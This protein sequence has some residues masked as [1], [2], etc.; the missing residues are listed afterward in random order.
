MRN[1]AAQIIHERHEAGVPSVLQDSYQTGVSEFWAAIPSTPAGIES[2][3]DA[4]QDTAQL[5]AR[6]IVGRRFR[7]ARNVPM[8][9]TERSLLEKMRELALANAEV[10]LRMDE[11]AFADEE[12]AGNVLPLGSRLVSG[13][14]TPQSLLQGRLHIPSMPGTIRCLTDFLAG[15]NTEEQNG[16]A[17]DERLGHIIRHD[18]ALT[19]SLLRLVNSPL[20]EER[21][22]G[23]NVATV[24]EAVA[25]VGG[26][27]LASLALAAA[28]IGGGKMAMHGLSLREFW[29]HSLMTACLASALARQAGFDDPERFFT[30]GLL[31]DVGRL[32]LVDRL[33]RDV[34]ALYG[35]AAAHNTPFHLAERRVLG[36]EHGRVG[37]ELMER[38][39]LDRALT[40]A[41]REHHTQERNME[42]PEVAAVVA[43]ADCMARALGYGYWHDSH[44]LPPSGGAWMLLGI[45][46]ADLGGIGRQAYEEFE[47]ASFVFDREEE[48][49]E[50]TA[51]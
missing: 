34:V 25:I 19:L 35:D 27:Q 20:Y 30:A 15:G 41:V 2:G 28:E 10:M 36:F 7:H 48:Q 37:A 6:R 13:S 16:N 12:A 49:A 39:N 38:W 24:R 14:H 32:L 8:S 5:K 26:R 50:R 21:R 3:P 33:G 42:H 1:T 43:V 17:S 29:R 47:R 22:G 45:T 46:M 40:E 31:H 18:I 51:A 11:S 44:V 4:V 9:G 23:C